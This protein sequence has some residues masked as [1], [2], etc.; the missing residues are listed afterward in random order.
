MQEVRFLFWNLNRNRPFEEIV[1][2]VEH[3]Q[4]DVLVLA[5]V[6]FNVIDL[7]NQLAERGLSFFYNPR[8]SQCKKITIL[9][10]FNDHFLKLTT[11]S[12]RYTINVLELPSLEKIILA[13]VHVPD[14]SRNERENQEVFCRI[15]AE[16]IKK[17]EFERGIVKTIVVGDFNMNPFETAL[18]SA[19]SLHAISSS[20]VAE[21]LSRI[22]QGKQYRFFYNP[23]W[24]LQGDVRNKVAGSYYYNTSNYLNS[25]WNTFDQVLIRPELIPN[26]DKDSLQILSSDGVKSLLSLNERPNKSYSDHLPLFFMLKLNTIL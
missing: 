20:K 3:H 21:K 16:D 9:T 11:E 22:V 5:E 8:R 18:L 4:V 26:F 17:Q 24:S 14:K 1:N 10:R 6:D 2:I 15:F 12:H 23:M 25:F 7:L 13:R 19:E